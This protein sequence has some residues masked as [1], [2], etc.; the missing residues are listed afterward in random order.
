MTPSTYKI[1]ARFDGD[2]QQAV[3]YCQRLA[4]EYP[5]LFTEYNQYAEVIKNHERN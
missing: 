3:E 1:L 2:R 4:S 5:A